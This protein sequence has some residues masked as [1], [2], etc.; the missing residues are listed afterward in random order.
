MRRNFILFTAI[1]LT[2][3]LIRAQDCSCTDMLSSLIAKVESNYAGYYHKVKETQDS[4]AYVQLKQQLRQNAIETSYIDCYTPMNA[5]LSFF[6]DKHLFISEFPR[7]SAAQSDSLFA[8]LPKRNDIAHTKPMALND[9]LAGTWHSAFE[10][11]TFIPV[12]ANTYH[13][14]VTRTRV[15]QWLPGFVRMEL[16]R[17]GENQYDIRYYRD[18]FSWIRFT[19]IHLYKRLFLS[20]GIYKFAKKDDTDPESQYIH[21]EAP[22]QPLFRVLDTTTTLI[23]I[24]S[25]LINQQVL[26]SILMSNREQILSSRNFIIDLRSNQGGNYIW[27]GIGRIANTQE[28]APAAN[29]NNKEPYL[30]LASADNAA[31]FAPYKNFVGDDSVG[32]RYYTELHERIRNNIGTIIPF[33]FYSPGPDTARREVFP[34]PARIAVI[35]DKGV[36]SAAEAIVQNLRSQSSKVKL[37]GENTFGMID[38]V[39]VNTIH[40]GGKNNTRYYFGYPTFFS[41]SVLTHPI[42]PMGIPPDVY[43]PNEERDWVMWVKEKMKQ[44]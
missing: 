26:D 13:G 41:P 4:T 28:Y 15:P 24:P 19:D 22:E 23:T 25:A 9:P 2:P 21:Y 7:T 1:L 40:F 35:I 16:K 37:Y 3:L 18:N 39:N 14:V 32:I 12:D 6:K 42:N 38:Y 20:F 8:L 17:T 33:G 43:V 29:A 34:N 31:Y 30:M 36:A 5:Y 44:E 10:Q 27:S 11:L